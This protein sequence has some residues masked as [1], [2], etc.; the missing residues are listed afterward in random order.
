MIENIKKDFFNQVAVALFILLTIWW[1]AL[2]FSGFKSGF[3]NY[4]FGAVYGPSM[5]ILGAAFGLNI[6]RSWGGFKSVI[7]RVL[8]FL[9]FG[10][11]AEFFGQVTFSIYNIVLHVEVPYPSFADLG[12]FSNIPFYLYGS[13]LLLKASG[14]KINLKT[15]KTQLQVVIIPLAMLSISY[16]LF[17]RQYQFD[18][19]QPIKIFLD[20]GYPLGQALY[21]SIALL[22]YSLSQ[23]F[24]GG[25]MKRKI[26]L[27]I[28]AFI[29]QYFADFNFLFQSN[30][31]T[32]YNG[33]YGDYLYLV[34]Y[35]LMTIGLLEFN[36]KFIRKKLE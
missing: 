6:A 2:Y 25:I 22:V 32:W 1:I 11:L 24:L 26:L 35:F 23:K 21:V 13:F 33:G 31:G 7:G 16:F 9:S 27:L 4:L 19:S 3:Q 30:R 28:L 15:V 5:S 34:A 36:L 18:W 14:A 8:I 10:L 29:A 17:L 12:F 20:F